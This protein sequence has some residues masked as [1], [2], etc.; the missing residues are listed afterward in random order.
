MKKKIPHKI[1][2]FSHIKLLFI[3]YLFPHY[4]ISR[5]PG[6]KKHSTPHT[7]EMYRIFSGRGYIPP[8]LFFSY[9]DLD[10]DLVFDLH[11]ALPMHIS[12]SNCIHSTPFPWIEKPIY[13][14]GTQ[15][16]QLLF[17]LRWDS[18]LLTY[19]LF[20]AKKSYISSRIVR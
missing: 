13:S 18:F 3:A 9:W 4:Y 2:T 15:H 20:R 1:T 5:D 10:T 19:L 11:L 6:L 17:F 14:S 16:I 7:T 12:L 8:F